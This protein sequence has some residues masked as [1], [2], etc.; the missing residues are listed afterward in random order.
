M[1]TKVMYITAVVIASV[2]GAYYY[3][4]GSGKKLETLDARNVSFTAK[5]IKLTQTKDNGELDLTAD[6]EELT[7]WM[8]TNESKLTHLNVQMYNQ[9][10]VDSTFWAKQAYGYDDNA[11]VVLSGEVIAKKWSQ[12]GLI[13]FETEK[14]TGF[15]KDKYVETDVAVNVTTP[16]ASFVSQGLKADLADGQYEFFNIRG[17][18]APRS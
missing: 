10:K 18:Y 15:P 1:D 5:Q 6:V 11:R 3:Y 9:G 14:L 17:N 7:Q 8:Q 16:Q 13:Q 2:A 4:S 12:S